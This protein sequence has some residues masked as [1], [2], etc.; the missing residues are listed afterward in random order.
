MA[1]LP[2]VFSTNP[3]CAV[4]LTVPLEIRRAP[5]ADPA[6]VEGY[7][8]VWNTRDLF[9][10]VIERGAFKATLAR[11]ASEGTRPLM[12]W[13]H[14]MAEPVG[15]WTSLVEDEVGLRA[16]GRLVTDASRG[17]DAAALIEA[18]A[19]NGLSIGFIVP[20]GASKLDRNTGVRTLTAI[21]LYEISLVSFPGQPAARVQRSVP[22][23]A[24]QARAVAARGWPGML[25][26]SAEPDPET[27]AAARRLARD[28][29]AA[30]RQMKEPTS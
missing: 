14:D 21:D 2:A 16:T 27:E 7:A 5:A 6:V 11:H 15:V 29:R 8:A 19:L 3:R 28:I 23:S 9:G 26:G 24:R 30:V 13:Q 25:T 17:Q 1:G 18:G 4:Q 22:A 20:E 10:D 12:L